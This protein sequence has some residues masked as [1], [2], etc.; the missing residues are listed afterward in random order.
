[1]EL[2]AQE[3]QRYNRKG[4]VGLS[5]VLLLNLL[6]YVAIPTLVKNKWAVLFP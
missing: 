2:I 1:M 5:L 6:I 4:L 3:D